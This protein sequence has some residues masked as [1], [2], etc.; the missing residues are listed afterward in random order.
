MLCWNPGTAQVALLP[1]PDAARR[2]DRYRM[3]CLASDERLH[4]MRFPERMAVVY[5]EA[6]HLIVRD[7]CDPMAVHRALLPLDEYRAGCAADMPEAE[8]ARRRYGE[9]APIWSVWSV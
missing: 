8:E 4:R 1:W 6:M 7:R 9:I 3:T 2:S 5:V